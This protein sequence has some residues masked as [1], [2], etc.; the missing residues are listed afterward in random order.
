[1]KF[2]L[3]KIGR[4]LVPS[5]SPRGTPVCAVPPPQNATDSFRIPRWKRVLDLTA[6]ILLLPVV[7]PLALGIAVL[8]RLVSRGPIL[9]KQ[10]RMGYR[11]K[12][13]MCLKFRTMVVGADTTNHQGHLDHLMASNAPMVKLDARGDSRIIPLGLLLRSA[14]LDELPQLINVLRGEMSL[15]GP[16]PCLAYEFDKYLPWQRERFNTLPG[17]TGLWQV[18]GKNRTTFSEMMHLDIDYVRRKT[19]WLDVLIIWKTLPAVV[20]QMWDLKVS[21]PRRGA[22]CADHRTPALQKTAVLPPAV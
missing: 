18:S 9:F 22:S 4:P 1:M 3:Q 19:L 11:C 10:E 8:I 16:R 13:F 21:K 20:V 6:V 14:G 12:T 15:V 5:L 17:L 2:T 7:L